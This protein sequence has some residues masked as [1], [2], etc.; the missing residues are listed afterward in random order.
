MTTEY[1]NAR[2][3]GTW[4]RIKNNLPLRLTYRLIESESKIGFP[5]MSPVR[6]GRPGAPIPRSF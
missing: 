6:E 2:H 4:R 3:T 1:P 5:M